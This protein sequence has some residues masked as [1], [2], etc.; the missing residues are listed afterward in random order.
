MKLFYL[1]NIRMPTEKAHGLQIM[2]NCA[3]FAENGAQVTLYVARRINTPEL[4]AVQDIYAHYGV[5]RNFSVRRV[6]CLDL[7]PLG[8]AERLLFAVQALSFTLVLLVLMFFRRAELYYS[9]DVLTLVALSLIKPRC[10]LVYEAHALSQAR[11]GEWLQRL[12]VRRVGLVVAITGHLAARLRERGAQRII[13]EHDGFRA[14]RFTDL[15]NQAAA[16]R[17]LN[18]PA[19]AFI[20]GYVGRLHTMSMSKGVDTLIDAIA[21]SR[22]PISLC[23]VGGP[24]QIAAQLHE[25]WRAHALPEANFLYA[26]QVVPAEVPRYLAAFDVCALPLPYTEHF[27]HYASPLKLFEYMRAGKPILASDLPALAEVVCNEKT[28]LLCPPA[29]AAAFGVALIRLYEDERLRARLGAAAQAQS[30]QYTWSARAARILSAARSQVSTPTD[31]PQTRQ[32]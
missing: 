12:C 23:L 30:A 32:R 18:L 8:R 26:G 7:L 5:P 27:A 19:D 3:A 21:A 31:A 1:A 29:D 28:A 2:Q 4:R 13:V 10:K 22:R 15:P 14:E 16:R 17:A 25:R 9:R 6:P 11:L 24:D 20:V